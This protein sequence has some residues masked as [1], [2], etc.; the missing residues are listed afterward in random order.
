MKTTIII[1]LCAMLL[2]EGCYS[3][4]AITQDED[5]RIT[6]MPDRNIRIDLKDDTEIEVEPYRYISVEAPSNFVYGTGVRIDK[7]TG[8]STEF[9]G[10]IYP[11]SCDS[12]PANISS[13]W[14]SKGDRRYDFHLSDGIVTQFN[15]G[16]FVTVDSTDDP[17]LWIC[18]GEDYWS[19]IQINNAKIPFT[20]IS[21]IE[22]SRF[23]AGYT[24]LCVLGVGAGVFMSLALLFVIGMSGPHAHD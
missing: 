8:S 16:D 14:Y 17:G 9:R 22:E 24:V 12:N 15:L 2:L 23:S 7:A 3:Y 11:V 4:R 10:I 13:E 19:G 6:L 1:L 18:S 20:D 5:G 21:K